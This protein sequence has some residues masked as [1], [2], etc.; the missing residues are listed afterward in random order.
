MRLTT[1]LVDVYDNS[2]GELRTEEHI[3]IDQT[4]DQL[5]GLLD[6][7]EKLLKAVTDPMEP[8]TLAPATDEINGLLTKCKQDIG[9]LETAIKRQSGWQ[10]MKGQSST[11]SSEMILSNLASST[12]ALRDI[13][14]RY[15][16]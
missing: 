12:T 4:T 15:T 2:R 1:D 5:S 10:S 11:W 9:E 14:V 6:V 16:S 13:V 3:D 7:L 8:T